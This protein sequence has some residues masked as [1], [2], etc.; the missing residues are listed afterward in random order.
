[1]DIVDKL[2]EATVNY[3]ILRNI[4]WEMVLDDFFNMHRRV[5]NSASGTSKS[6]KIQIAMANADTML[7][8]LQKFI[9]AMPGMEKLVKAMEQDIT[10]EIDKRMAA[11]KLNI[12]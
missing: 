1:M 6:K 5:V 12:R 2:N 9:D 11:G 10:K 4:R 3:K 7:M 8:Y